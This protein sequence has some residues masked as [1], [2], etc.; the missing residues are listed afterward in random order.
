M[1]S[2]P[3]SKNRK[4][5]HYFKAARVVTCQTS[6]R[7]VPRVRHRISQQEVCFQCYISYYHLSTGA[8][9]YPPQMIELVLSLHIIFTMSQTHTLLPLD[10]IADPPSTFPPIYR[11]SIAQQPPSP[12]ACLLRKVNSQGPS[13]PFIIVLF[14]KHSPLFFSVGYGAMNLYYTGYGSQQALG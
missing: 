3:C 14:R 1:A 13:S 5:C 11:P 10:R 6:M 9:L 2:N 12:T 4:E 7:D 8:P